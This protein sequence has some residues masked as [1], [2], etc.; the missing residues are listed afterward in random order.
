M[1]C[2][3]MQ[4]GNCGL[5]LCR[6]WRNLLNDKLRSRS[7]LNGRPDISDARG[8]IVS[9]LARGFGKHPCV[10]RAKILSRPSLG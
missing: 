8:Q 4:D 5:S 1:Q 9:L 6:A 7:R 2:P 10:S 3:L